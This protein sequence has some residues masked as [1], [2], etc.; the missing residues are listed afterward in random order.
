V[1]TFYY[2]NNNRTSPTE[3]KFAK[4]DEID[5]EYKDKVDG[6]RTQFTG[7]GLE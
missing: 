7:K 2:C 5:P 3:F 6:I 1:K 4:L